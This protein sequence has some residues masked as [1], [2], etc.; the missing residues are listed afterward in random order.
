VRTVVRRMS[1]LG[2]IDVYKLEVPRLDQ[3]VL[4]L[5]YLFVSPIC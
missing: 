2:Q 3:T 5:M 1:A 4:L